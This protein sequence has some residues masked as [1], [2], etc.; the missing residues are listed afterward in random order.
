MRVAILIY[1]TCAQFEVVLASLFIK[2]KHEMVTV[3]LDDRAVT[4]MEGFLLKPHMLLEALAP[5]SIGAFIIPG[6]Q[7]DTIKGNLIL[8]KKLRSFNERKILIAAICGGPLHLG[9]A[10]LLKDRRFTSSIYKERPDDFPGG[11]YVDED[12]V[13]DGNIITAQPNAYVD[14][15]LLLG[16]RLDVFKDQADYDETVREFR[17]F[18]R[19]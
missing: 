18:E 12:L 1:D 3:G 7:P 19:A 15:A 6:G 17:G 16:K 8:G 13:E 4:S 5:A 2:Q 14:F 10:G 9:T 11:T